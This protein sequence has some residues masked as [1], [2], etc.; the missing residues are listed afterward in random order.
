[1]PRPAV[2]KLY[3]WLIKHGKAPALLHRLFAW[4]L[5]T[6]LAAPSMW[7]PARRRPPNPPWFRTIFRL[8]PN[9]GRAVRPLLSRVYNRGPFVWW[10]TRDRKSTRLNYSHVKIS[11]AVLCLNK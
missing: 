6:V 9:N 10:G 2:L 3:A 11:Y 7:F 8:L 1:M 5:P 4:Y